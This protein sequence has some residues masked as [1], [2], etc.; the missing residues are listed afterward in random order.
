MQSRIQKKGSILFRV[1]LRAAPRHCAIASWAPQPPWPPRPDRAGRPTLAWLARV[2]VCTRSSV[3][4]APWCLELRQEET[5][6]QPQ[7]PCE[8]IGL[9]IIIV[10]DHMN[11]YGFSSHFKQGLISSSL[12]CA[13]R[14]MVTVL[15][16]V[17]G[18]R[19]RCYS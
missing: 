2:G 1:R 10:Q 4:R 5:M 9:F 18:S 6:L 16:A 13:Y 19:R 17:A 12:T 14:N 15:H 11:S 7:K 3:P 8:F